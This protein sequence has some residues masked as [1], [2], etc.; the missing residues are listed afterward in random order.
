MDPGLFVPA[1]VD[2]G[3]AFTA[4]TEAPPDQPAAPTA[5]FRSAFAQF[6]TET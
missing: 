4:P 2:V 1:I 6:P 5:I 3:I